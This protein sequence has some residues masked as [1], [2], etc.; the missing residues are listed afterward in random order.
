LPGDDFELRYE[1]I[2]SNFVSAIDFLNDNDLIS[3]Y[4]RDIRKPLQNLWY[5][6]AKGMRIQKHEKY[7]DS[8]QQLWT[9]I[10]AKS[11]DEI[12]YNVQKLLD[13]SLNTVDFKYPPEYT[14]CEKKFLNATL[15]TYL[16]ED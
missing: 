7:Y 8:K 10:Y 12:E 11:L 15:G 5:T 16:R 2:L 9:R 4:W 3:G 1:I 6:Y 14:P 13:K